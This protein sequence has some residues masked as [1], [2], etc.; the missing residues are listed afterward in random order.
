MPLNPGAVHSAYV[1]SQSDDVQPPLSSSDVL[2]T[3]E[4]SSIEDFESNVKFDLLA[5][6]VDNY[7]VN[8]TNNNV[9]PY[10]TFKVPLG[11]AKSVSSSLSGNGTPTDT[12]DVIIDSGC[13]KHMFPDRDL[14]LQYK[15]CSHS[16]VILAD[17]S[18]TAC[19]GIGTVQ[20]FLG[21][22]SIIL[23]DV[24]HVPCL[25][26]PLLS[27]RCFR[28]LKGCSFLS[29]N[30][31]CFLTFPTFFFTWMIHPIASSKEQRYKTRPH[32]FLIADL[33]A[34]HPPLATTHVVALHAVLYPH[35][36]LSLKRNLHLF[37]HSS[38]LYHHH[39]YR[40]TSLII[41]HHFLVYQKM[42][43]YSHAL[44]LH[45][46]LVL[47]IIRVNHLLLYL[48]NRSMFNR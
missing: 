1:H 17:K 12:F 28:R 14:F 32:Q 46:L 13:T 8:S 29:D 6:D 44:H 26:C 30:L 5:D 21:G 24:L 43:L 31:G 10:P 4:E 48:L 22:K 27:V 3:I 18:K 23:H 42:I 33:L 19:L 39:L 34:W 25:R 15:T 7:E 11:L 47:V 16:F 37:L 9:Y 20:L 38:I 2:D 45:L 35:P 40:W 41:T 36:L